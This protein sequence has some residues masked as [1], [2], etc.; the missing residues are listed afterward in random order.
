M[1]VRPHAGLSPTQFADE[2]HVRV[3]DLRGAA[4]AADT[5]VVL[6]DIGNRLTA[7]DLGLTVLVG[8]IL[9]LVPL[10]AGA[11]VAN[12]QLAAAST[13]EHEIG[14]RLALGASR[15]RLV[16]QLLVESLWVSG[17]A[18]LFGLLAMDWGG[19]LINFLVR[20]LPTLSAEPDWRVFVFVAVVS[21]YV[22]L[23]TAVAPTR[24]ALATEPVGPLRRRE[25]ESPSATRH[26]RARNLLVG[27]QAAASLMWLVLTALLTRSLVTATRLDV[28]FD[29]E[30]TLIVMPGVRALATTSR[31][32]PRAGRRFSSA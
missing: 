3:A 21:V 14:T 27:A 1:L 17:A 8:T 25:S 13:R 26:G 32:W 9:A 5:R 23:V 15:A 28:G 29:V 6:R 20:D 12:L 2:L 10:L 11:N 18:G 24:L 4:Y 7:T 16:R 19:S 30:Q 31:G 22:G